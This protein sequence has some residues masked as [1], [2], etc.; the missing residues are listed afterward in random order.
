MIMVQVS[1]LLLLLWGRI[2]SLFST[3]RDRFSI[4]VIGQ[5]GLLLSL[6]LLWSLLLG[7]ASWMKVIINIWFII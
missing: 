3:S 6:S 1:L 7:P 2:P 5:T 4:V